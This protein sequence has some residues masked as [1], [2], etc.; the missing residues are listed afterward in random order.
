[1]KHLFVPAAAF[2]LA[3]IATPTPAHAQAESD[4]FVGTFDLSI[5]DSDF[6]MTAAPDSAVMSIERADD[7]LVMR[8]DL[9]FSQLGEPGFVAFDM[10]TDGGTYE[11]TTHEG[12]QEFQLSWDGDVLVM[13]TQAESNIGPIAVV[14]RMSADHDGD[15][16]FVGRTVDVP[17]VGPSES[18]LVYLRRE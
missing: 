9:H 13:T 8:R 10:P 7:R 2:L 11:A 15:R 4:Q 17:G 3:A 18:T 5:A 14:D 1:M 12:V 16:I 6:G